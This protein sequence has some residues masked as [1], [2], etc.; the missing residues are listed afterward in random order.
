[1]A[2]AKRLGNGELSAGIRL[3]L[4]HTAQS[5]FNCSAYRAA[6]WTD[7]QSHVCLKTEEHTALSDTELLLEAANGADKVGLVMGKGRI[8]IGHWKK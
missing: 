1:M 5:G 8:E 4:L 2:E 6:Y 3:A 7:G